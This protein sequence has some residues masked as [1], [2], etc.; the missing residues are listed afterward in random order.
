MRTGSGRIESGSRGVTRDVRGWR[1]ARTEWVRQTV[2]SRS[3][4]IKLYIAKFRR[5]LL[6]LVIGF[7]LLFVFSLSGNIVFY[8]YIPDDWI[9]EYHSIVPYGEVLAGEEFWLVSENEV[10]RK[11]SVIWYD[12]LLC[13]GAKTLGKYVRVGPAQEWVG[14]LTPHK[15]EFTRPW[16]F[17]DPVPPEWSERCK[18]EG[19]VCYTFLTFIE[20][21]IAYE[22]GS[23]PVRQIQP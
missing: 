15:R 6:S 20:R 11:G 13:S 2:I 22:S 17:T 19:S 1:I 12:T 21:C 10:H 9:I 18:I 16:T 7:P 4:E 23:F 3:E 14:H 5:Y 8:K